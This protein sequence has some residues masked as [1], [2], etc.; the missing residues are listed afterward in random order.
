M[1]ERAAY[2]RRLLA[3]WER[4]GLSQAEFCRRRGLKAVNLA[5]WKRGD[6]QLMM[7]AELSKRRCADGREVAKHNR[8]RDAP[9]DW[10]RREHQAFADDLA[11]CRPRAFQN[12]FPA[13]SFEGAH[14]I[15]RMR[16][17]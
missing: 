10:A 12:G 7:G 3:E 5:W 1:S 17:G 13:R 8:K 4:S 6:V 9:S 16:C 15:L 11:L 14:G 2:W